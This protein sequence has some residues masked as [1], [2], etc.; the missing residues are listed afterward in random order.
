MAERRLHDPAEKLDKVNQD[1][2][3][4]DFTVSLADVTIV[5]LGGGESN[6]KIKSSAI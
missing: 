4:P 1:V 2:E 6:A 3:D 5:R